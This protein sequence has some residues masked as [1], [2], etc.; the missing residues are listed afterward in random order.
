[1]TDTSTDFQTEEH[2]N[3]DGLLYRVF[4]DY[5][6]PFIIHKKVRPVVFIIFLGFLF[7]SLSLLPRV[8]TGLD[9]KLYVKL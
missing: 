3:S 5:Y 7:A 1:M 9:Q 2:E 6:A 4:K 8:R